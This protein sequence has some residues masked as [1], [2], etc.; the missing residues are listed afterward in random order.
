MLFWC[1]RTGSLRC[2]AQGVD[3]EQGRVVGPGHLLVGQVGQIVVAAE[4]LADTPPEGVG[5]EHPLDVADGVTVGRVEAADEGREAPPL[6][7]GELF[8]RFGQDLVGAVVVVA[9]GVVVQVVVRRPGLVGLPLLLDR[10]AEQHRLGHVAG[11]HG[12]QEPLQ[13]VRVLDE[14][15][16]VEVGVDDR[17][18]RR[19][20]GVADGLG[21]ER[22]VIAHGQA[23]AVRALAART[24]RATRKAPRARMP[25][26]AS[27]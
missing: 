26:R 17:Q 7:L 4:D 14:V 25:A 6:G 24:A 9:A 19:L 2:A 21:M 13:A 3:V 20:L 12:S 11:V 23:Q 5:F 1:S 16:V 10:Q 18:K 15:D 8:Q 27:R 22:G